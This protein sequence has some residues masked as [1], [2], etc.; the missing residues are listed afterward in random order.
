MDL[1]RAAPLCVDIT[2]SS[3]KERCICSQSEQSAA[4]QKRRNETSIDPENETETEEFRPGEQNC[5]TERNTACT[6]KQTV[7]Y[8]C[9]SRR[10]G[11]TEH[12]N[13]PCTRT[14]CTLWPVLVEV[15]YCSG[16]VLSVESTEKSTNPIVRVL[17]INARRNNK[18]ALGSSEKE[19]TSR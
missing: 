2:Y 11:A 6:S 19:K 8:S 17:S 9:T 14:Q 18:W 10:S 1:D 12:S 4:V 15:V 7:G 3:Y 5:R 16:W 13:M